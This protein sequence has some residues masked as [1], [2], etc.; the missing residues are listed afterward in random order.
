MIEEDQP[1]F[2]IEPVVIVKGDRVVV[3]TIWGDEHGTVAFVDDGM[4]AVDLPQD[5][6]YI[7]CSRLKVVPGA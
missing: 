7:G 6:I 5:R 3:Q 4:A 2:D 1:M